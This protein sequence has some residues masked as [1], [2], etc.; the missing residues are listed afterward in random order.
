MYANGALTTPGLFAVQANSNV[1]NVYKDWSAATAFPNNGTVYPVVISI[2]Y[3]T[4]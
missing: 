2:T 4:D 3:L 1:A